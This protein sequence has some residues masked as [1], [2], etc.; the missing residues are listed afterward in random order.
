VLLI[1]N[2]VGKERMW[3][4][5]GVRGRLVTNPNKAVATFNERERQKRRRN[6]TD[7]AAL[8]SSS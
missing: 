4:A 8:R 1:S 2:F 5:D 7:F 3:K 6:R